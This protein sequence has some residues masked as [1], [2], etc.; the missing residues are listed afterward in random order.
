MHITRIKKLKKQIIIQSGKNEKEFFLLSPF[1]ILCN[2]NI[3][4][5]DVLLRIAVGIVR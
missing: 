5:L 3:F 4:L 2:E 1:S